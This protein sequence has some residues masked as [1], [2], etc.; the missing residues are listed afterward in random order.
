MSDHFQDSSAEV[1]N[2]S[3]PLKEVVSQDIE[4]VRDTG[5][6]VRDSEH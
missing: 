4:R 5:V 2:S 3:D 6:G 1:H